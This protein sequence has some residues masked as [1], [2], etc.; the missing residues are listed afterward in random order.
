MVLSQRCG[1][2]CFLVGPCS[3]VQYSA[4]LSV[5]DGAARARRGTIAAGPF[6]NC[7]VDQL[8]DPDGTARIVVAGELDLAAVP[9]LRG[10]RDAL[11]RQGRSTILDLRGLTFMDSS[12]LRVLIEAGTQHEAGWGV[13]LLLP[14]AGPVR[15]LIAIAG[16]EHALPPPPVS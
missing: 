12:G 16:V 7:T 10:V 13:R 8:T 2:P 4:G 15:R 3:F 9:T 6:L 1:S 14:E 5:P 11:R